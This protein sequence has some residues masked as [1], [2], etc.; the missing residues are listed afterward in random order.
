MTGVRESFERNKDGLND[1]F[2]KCQNDIRQSFNQLVETGQLE[3]AMD[4]INNQ[5]STAILEFEKR[6]IS[7]RQ[8]LEN[9]MKL[10]FDTQNQSILTEWENAVISVKSQIEMLADTFKAEMNKLVTEQVRIPAIEKFLLDS[11]ERKAFTRLPFDYI[12]KKL[13]VPINKV[14]EISENL[15]FEGRLPARIDIVS[16][17]LIFSDVLDK[18]DVIAPPTSPPADTSQIVP[19]A[20]KP[21]PI[22]PI[23]PLKEQPQM[24]DLDLPIPEDPQQ[25]DVDMP[26][27]D[28]PDALD[29][30]ALEPPDLVGD[31]LDK[32]P[33]SVEF[34]APDSA[35]STPTI[36][37]TDVPPSETN[38]SVDSSS[39]VPEAPIPTADL[40]EQEEEALSIISFFK[41]SVEELSE[42]EHAEKRRLREEKKKQLAAAKQQTEK[43]EQLPEP[44][45]TPAEAKS[46]P[47]E[48]AVVCVVCGQQISKDD[49]TVISC[50]H[51]CG[52]Y[53]HKKELLEKGFC[54]SCQEEV[55]EVDIEFSGLL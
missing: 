40:T 30:T 39:P 20:P 48:L 43:E 6:R 55:R 26:I 13:N 51:A 12:A 4:T 36:T 19:P 46:I 21:P 22:S 44:T 32:A 52:A 3:D 31:I 34:E 47:P 17:M 28:T 53:A 16:Q 10:S 1:L 5:I 49:P 35:T 9:K 37:T 50:P 14:E 41:S 25:L 18:I 15:I 33:D 54:P 23:T 29:L 11:A 42:E 24:L 7:V 8:L 38:S 45:I 27:P 2:L